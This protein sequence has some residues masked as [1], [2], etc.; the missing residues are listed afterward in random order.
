VAVALGGTVVLLAASWLALYLLVVHHG[1]ILHRLDDLDAAIRDVQ[2]AGRGAVTLARSGPSSTANARRVRL[3][4]ERSLGESRLN[5][6]GLKPGARAPAFRLPTPYGGTVALEDFIGRRVLVVLSDP[7]CEP[8]DRLAAEL[9]RLSSGGSGGAAIVLV[10]RGD[11][12]ENRELAELH[13]FAFPVGLQ[14]GWEVS[15]QF[16]IFETPVAFLVDET[17]VVAHGVARGRDEVLA[18]AQSVFVK[19]EGY[20]RAFG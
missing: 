3:P 8:C 16:G 1:R 13:G 15:K 18:L 2:A 5:R 14:R 4:T 9:G 10:S 11:R 12:E 20:E 19:E 6:T 17:G 7:G